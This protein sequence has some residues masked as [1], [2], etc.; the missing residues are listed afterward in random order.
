MSELKML[1]IDLGATSG[2]GIIGSFD[3]KKLSLEE[4]HRF[5]DSSV[6]MTGS[7]QW[8]IN[9]IYENIKTA[10]GK[11]P[12]DIKTIGI[13][14]WG[15][16]YGLLDK[17]GKLLT[18]P[19]HYR[20]TRTVGIQDYAEQF[21]PKKRLYDITGIQFCDFNTVWQLAAELRDNPELVAAADLVIVVVIDKQDLGSLHKGHGFLTHGKAKAHGAGMGELAVDLFASGEL[22]FDLV[23]EAAKNNGSDLAD[24]R[25]TRAG[26]HIYLLWTVGGPFSF[27]GK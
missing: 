11:S 8:N 23:V 18:N 27:A 4:N 26:L 14:T 25:I 24:I 6:N 22:E 7:L 2:R 1:A 12:K 9:D 13:D 20:D 10:I 21:L 16:D 19:V 17:H 3:G 15:V 5:D